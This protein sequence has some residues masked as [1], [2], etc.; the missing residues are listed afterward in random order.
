MAGLHLNKQT[1]TK[2]NTL[3]TGI[4][5]SLVAAADSA[6][7]HVIIYTHTRIICERAPSF[8]PGAHAEKDKKSIPPR[9]WP[10]NTKQPAAAIRAVQQKN[11]PAVYMCMF[12][13]ARAD[14]KVE[15]EGGSSNN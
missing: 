7:S 1:H 11:N 2:K 9:L 5:P 13:R 4:I 3:H 10:L 8:F 12:E 6:D 15:E 14:E